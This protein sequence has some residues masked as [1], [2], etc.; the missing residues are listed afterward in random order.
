MEA[1]RVRSITDFESY[2]NLLNL[3]LIPNV[4]AL[5]QADDKL[6]SVKRYS[7]FVY[8][9]KSFSLMGMQMD[10]LLRKALRS[11]LDCEFD[12][13][14]EPALAKIEAITSSSLRKSLR[15]DVTKYQDFGSWTR[16]VRE[17]FRLSN[18]IIETKFTED[19]LISYMPTITNILRDVTTSWNDFEVLKSKV[20]RY[21]VVCGDELITGHPDIVTDSCILD[22]KNVTKF[23]SMAE[24]SILQVLAYYALMKP[25]DD[26]LKYVGFVLPMQRYVVLYDLSD[27]D[28]SLFRTYLRRRARRI[29]IDTK[30]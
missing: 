24:S 7:P 19:D 11:T 16:V 22:I 5:V 4:L 30:V 12:L 3:E 13:G 27:W 23:T 10:Y 26:K 2:E 21:N 1:I 18:L 8:S 14:V 28:S 15:K 9:T 25:V 6:S 29:R 17:S 20:V